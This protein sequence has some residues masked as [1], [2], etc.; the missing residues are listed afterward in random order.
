VKSKGNICPSPHLPSPVSS[1]EFIHPVGSEGGREK[2]VHLSTKIIGGSYKKYQGIVKQ[3]G[4]ILI[5]NSIL[6]VYK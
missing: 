6:I 5:R 2:Q 1:K 3:M 4:E